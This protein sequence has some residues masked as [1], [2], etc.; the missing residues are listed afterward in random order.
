M[1]EPRLF[2]LPEEVSSQTLKKLLDMLISGIHFTKKQEELA[3][4]EYENWDSA[5][6][7]FR[8]LNERQ[9]SVIVLRYG[10]GSDHPLSQRDVAVYH[11]MSKSGLRN[12][13]Q[14]AVKILRYNLRKAMDRQ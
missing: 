7:L 1:P 3:R 9:V 5:K 2:K 4:S 11:D 13:Q 12:V 8:N 6:A 10:L 14:A